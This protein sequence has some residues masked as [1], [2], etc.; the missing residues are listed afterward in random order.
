VLDSPHSGRVRPSGFDN[1]L[2][3]AALR[4]AED[5][6]VDGLYL[7]AT[8]RGIPLLAARWSRVYL[9]VNCHAD[10]TQQCHG[11]FADLQRDLMR[12][13]DALFE[14]AAAWSDARA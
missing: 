12:L 13:F 8:Q 7:P 9:D 3:D 10:A 11:E 6:F 5:S 2:D 14:R 1:V 4:T